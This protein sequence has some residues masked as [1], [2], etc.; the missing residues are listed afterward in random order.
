MNALIERFI[1]HG[2]RP[3]RVRKLYY[4]PWILERLGWGHLVGYLPARWREQLLKGATILFR[5]GIA[6]EISQ[7]VA[8]SAF[9][10]D[11]PGTSGPARL[12]KLLA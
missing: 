4:A 6:Q 2:L 7:E 1:V 8:F 5:K 3:E 12:K 9:W 10:S 11:P